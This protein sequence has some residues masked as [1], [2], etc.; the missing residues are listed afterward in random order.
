MITIKTSK[1]I[2]TLDW[3]TKKTNKHVPL[4]FVY[5][6]SEQY[7]SRA[8]QQ[9]CTWSKFAILSLKNTKKNQKN[10][11]LVF[12]QGLILNKVDKNI[13][14]TKGIRNYHVCSAKSINN[15]IKF[16]FDREMRST[17]KRSFSIGKYSNSG[18]YNN[19]S[20]PSIEVQSVRNKQKK[21]NN[22]FSPLKNG[23]SSFPYRTKNIFIERKNVQDLKFKGKILGNR[24]NYLG[25]TLLRT[26]A[27]KKLRYI[28][29]PGFK[30]ALNP[31]FKETVLS[32]KRRV[33]NPSFKEKKILVEQTLKSNIKL[34]IIKLIRTLRKYKKNK[35]LHEGVSG[36]H[37]TNAFKARTSQRS[38][39][40]ARNRYKLL[41]KSSYFGELKK[42][43]RI[44]LLNQ[45]YFSS[46]YRSVWNR[47]LNVATNTLL[48]KK[49][50]LLEKVFIKR[51]D[52]DFKNLYYNYFDFM[53]YNL[54]RLTNSLTSVNSGIL[55]PIPIR[56]TSEEK[57]IFLNSGLVLAVNFLDNNIL[58]L[59]TSKEEKGAKF[60]N[61][62][63]ASAETLENNQAGAHTLS[64][65]TYNKQM[66]ETISQITDSNRKG[67]YISANISPEDLKEESDIVKFENKESLLM[68][69]LLEDLVITKFKYNKSLFNTLNPFTGKDKLI[70][71]DDLNRLNHLILFK[72]HKKNKNLFYNSYYYKKYMINFFASMPQF[73]KLLWAF[74][75]ARNLNSWG[76]NAVHTS[77]NVNTYSTKLYLKSIEKFLSIDI[78]K[79][80]VLKISIKNLNLG[81]KRNA[82]GNIKTNFYNKESIDN[83]RNLLFN[84]YFKADLSSEEIKSVQTDSQISSNFIFNNTIVENKK[85]QLNSHSL[86]LQDSYIVNNLL[87]QK[88]ILSKY[89]STELRSNLLKIRFSALGLT[90]NKQKYEG[91]RES[92]RRIL[93]KSSYLW[94]QKG[95]SQQ[96][97]PNRKAII[98]L[99]KKNVTVLPYLQTHGSG[100]N[101]QSYGHIKS[102][103]SNLNSITSHAVLV[104]D[105]NLGI[106]GVDRKSLPRHRRVSNHTY[107][108]RIQ[109][110]LIKDVTL[111]K[112]SKSLIFN[113]S[114]IFSRLRS[115]KHGF[116]YF[117]ANSSKIIS[118]ELSAK[119][120]NTFDNNYNLSPYVCGKPIVKDFLKENSSTLFGVSNK[121]PFLTLSNR[122]PGLKKY[123]ALN[124]YG[125][126]YKVFEIRVNN[127]KFKLY[128]HIFNIKLKRINRLNIYSKIFNLF[129]TSIKTKDSV[130]SSYGKIASSGNIYNSRSCVINLSNISRVRA[131]NKG[132]RSALLK[133][134]H[135]A[136]MPV[137]LSTITA[138]AIKNIET[139][140]IKKLGSMRTRAIGD[141]RLSPVIA[142][143]DRIIRSV[144]VVRRHNKELINSTINYWL[145]EQEK[146]NKRS[147]MHPHLAMQI[148]SR[149]SSSQHQ[150]NFLKV[151]QL[152][153]MYSDGDVNKSFILNHFMDKVLQ[154]DNYKFFKRYNAYFQTNF[155]IDFTKMFSKRHKKSYT[156]K[157]L[158]SNIKKL[159][160][161]LRKIYFFYTS[162]KIIIKEK[163]QHVASVRFA[164][165]VKKKILNAIFKAI[166]SYSHKFHGKA[167]VRQNIS[168]LNSSR[169]KINRWLW[170]GRDYRKILNLIY[171]N[172]PSGEEL[173]I[174][175]K[176]QLQ[177]F[178]DE[179]SKKPILKYFIANKYLF[180]IWR[181]IK[182]NRRRT[183][184]IIKTSRGLINKM[185][186]LNYILFNYAEKNFKKVSYTNK[187]NNW[188]I[189]NKKL[190]RRH[191]DS[192]NMHLWWKGEASAF[193][194]SNKK[195]IFI[196]LYVFLI[197]NKLA[198]INFKKYFLFRRLMRKGQAKMLGHFVNLF[199]SK[200]IRPWKR[201]FFK[202][203]VLFRKTNKYINTKKIKQKLNKKEKRLLIKL[204]RRG[205]SHMFLG[206]TRKAEKVFGK[207]VLRAL[208]IRGKRKKK[209]EL[210]LQ[211]FK[212][213]IIL[214]FNKIMFKSFFYWKW[215]RILDD[216]S[217]NRNNFKASHN[218]MTALRV[219]LNNHK[220]NNQPAHIHTYGFGKKYAAGS[221]HGDLIKD[222]AN[223]LKIT[224][225][226]PLSLFVSLPSLIC[227]LRNLNKK[228]RKWKKVQIK[229]KT[230][231][232]S[233]R[234][235]KDINAVTSLL[236]LKPKFMK[237]D[238]MPLF[239]Q[240]TNI[241]KESQIIKNQIPAHDTL[242]LFNDYELSFTAIDTLNN[243]KIKFIKLFKNLQAVNTNHANYEARFALSPLELQLNK[244]INFDINLLPTMPI[245]QNLSERT[246]KQIIVEQK[247]TIIIASDRTRLEAEKNRLYHISNYNLYNLALAYLGRYLSLY[248]NIPSNSFSIGNR[249]INYNNNIWHIDLF[250][251]KSNGE[252]N[253]AEFIYF[254]R[255][256]TRSFDSIQRP[257][258]SNSTEKLEKKNKGLKVN[259]PIYSAVAYP[260]KEWLSKLIRRTPSGYKYDNSYFVSGLRPFD[261]P[262]TGEAKKIK[263]NNYQPEGFKSILNKNYI[264]QGLNS[265]FISLIKKYNYFMIDIKTKKEFINKFN[266]IL[267]Y[268]N[269]ATDSKENTQVLI[270]G[271]SINKEIKYLFT[272][273]PNRI[274]KSLKYFNNKK[275]ISNNVMPYLF[276]TLESK[277][278]STQTSTHGAE[279]IKANTIS[280]VSPI[281]NM[282]IKT[283]SKIRTDTVIKNY[284]LNKFNI[285][286]DHCLDTLLK[287]TA[288]D[289]LE[290]SGALSPFFDFSI[291]NKNISNLNKL[292]LDKTLSEFKLFRFFKYSGANTGTKQVISYSFTKNINRTNTLIS[293]DHTGSLLKISIS[294]ILKYFFNLMG[295]S[296]ISKPVFIFSHNK[297]NIQIS[298]FMF[299]DFY[300]CNRTIKT[301][302]ETVSTLSMGM[303]IYWPITLKNYKNLPK[304]NMPDNG[305]WPSYWTMKYYRSNRKPFEDKII[306]F[307]PGNIPYLS[308]NWY[309]LAVIGTVNN[310]RK[311]VG[312]YWDKKSKKFIRN[313]LYDYGPTYKFRKID[314]YEPYVKNTLSFFYDE[315]NSLS[316]ILERFYNCPIKLELNKLDLP[317]SDTN[318]MAQLI[319]ISGEE[320]KFEKIKR[321]FIYKFK[322]YNPNR[323][324]NKLNPNKFKN[325]I[326]N[327]EES[328]IS[329]PS[330]YKV[331]VAGRFY[332]HKIIPRK[333]VSS[334]QKGSMARRVVDLVE[335]ARYTNKSK[336]GSF[337]VTV[338]IS[339]VF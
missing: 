303:A 162:S 82:S 178:S 164:E 220:V 151:N 19:I 80:K 263:F 56:K 50:K 102:G 265:K 282:F 331:K 297:V 59:H 202:H 194:S 126:I 270:P 317:Y 260:T 95:I 25:N 238:N 6:L 296:L 143:S 77:I 148:N 44:A 168:R 320:Y 203:L 191:K 253:I 180:N 262:Y 192:S 305:N 89:R 38:R 217:S 105:K 291:D 62:L 24:F 290:L 281:G 2:K 321:N 37:Q 326:I 206:E 124:L 11:Q 69:N 212:E 284:N 39:A 298:Y 264:N 108:K 133:L 74:K 328:D 169:L 125:N 76:A 318:I 176:L 245:G 96:H 181:Y 232:N 231:K 159:K 57:K 219:P 150:I 311:L 157:H 312:G 283:P 140:N 241:F 33:I 244:N 153:F 138:G 289:N 46:R 173:S 145:L 339:H 103:S 216:S 137:R 287:G 141:L 86:I 35:D 218:P 251:K 163:R 275:K 274:R 329:I 210:F 92:S 132:L 42:S 285:N 200:L 259:L 211:K 123:K 135:K 336:R 223:N 332:K 185:T 31:R 165:K 146:Q 14:L 84:N 286:S 190:V 242:R 17:T 258:N 8:S 115:K 20:V 280:D 184:Q 109:Q 13:F 53:A 27:S 186:K 222:F 229:K 52:L 234:L 16:T 116:D 278:V 47:S 91:L 158:S 61:K 110:R 227:W 68:E 147:F 130:K 247:S 271:T 201:L 128:P 302:N 322:Y 269:P 21:T 179:K 310:L 10:S 188:L 48:L 94:P 144:E 75:M 277:F 197:D 213:K 246:H 119:K 208:R 256:E 225:L 58:S 314:Y 294:V 187:Y 28:Y 98:K 23:A 40:N 113:L 330:G 131:K 112:K 1:Q 261:T 295:L 301:W 167:N 161:R 335:K 268:H 9:F 127:Y 7:P 300:F 254:S 122:L 93:K 337:S 266:K 87:T 41:K 313:K 237:E 323:S 85:K 36:A 142:Q 83:V 248:R 72:K 293:L 235:K 319:G 22:H 34:K 306:P 63:G 299:N 182:I 12:G 196:L 267:S 134:K 174:K 226:Y 154:L 288:E 51:L 250:N 3:C 49:N 129:S 117:S 309:K 64:T 73:L 236:E 118:K 149:A 5:G 324:E 175:R 71:G 121:F 243:L 114:V 307:Y 136:S 255:H 99:L 233:Y 273:R 249:L 183:P 334:F 272:M 215:R 66:E 214:H 100:R 279:T 239:S 18:N 60:E 70:F 155:F 224:K 304:L 43:K 170:I 315:L 160:R 327:S 15:N 106:G 325:I 29:Y 78:N 90:E 88:L 139:R 111:G 81:V 107:A 257:L 166:K 193:S 292:G 221:E 4:C 205:I 207:K 333:T 240:N 230:Y 120:N 195:A 276:K 308:Q 101:V 338:W 204:R 189:N 252:Q 26:P 209:Y 55:S 97:A 54:I 152:G 30:N 171:N 316:Y 32:Y 79:Y 172:Y 177:L 45:I 104:S 199:H 228:L 65:V 198:A 67:S 156:K